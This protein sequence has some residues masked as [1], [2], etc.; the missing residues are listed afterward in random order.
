[1]HVCVPHH[2]ARRRARPVERA[3]PVDLMLYLELSFPF[4]VLVLLFFPLAGNQ[5]FGKILAR[6]VGQEVHSAHR[7]CERYAGT[8]KILRL[9]LRRRLFH[10]Y[11]YFTRFVC[12]DVC[13]L[14]YYYLICCCCCC[15]HIIN[16]PG[17]S[18]Q[19]LLLSQPLRTNP[20][21]D[22]ANF[23]GLFAIRQL[24]VIPQI[25][26]STSQFTDLNLRIGIHTADACFGFSRAT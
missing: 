4:S 6:Q 20:T 17:L 25:F 7:D 12:C 19:Y 3:R 9:H 14:F 18:S 26:Y 2:D 10:V 15:L 16:H 1:M 21:L 13:S 24:Q 23:R 11:T 5:I 8:I 22:S